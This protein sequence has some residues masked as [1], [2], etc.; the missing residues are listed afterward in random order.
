MGVRE[1][2]ALS[3]VREKAIGSRLLRLSEVLERTSISRTAI[4][5]LIARG[6]FPPPVK[7]GRMSRWIEFE[8]QA[9]IDRLA[10]ERKQAAISWLVESNGCEDRQL[11]LSGVAR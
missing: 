10:Q 4:Y 11:P 1:L 3:V 7:C 6:E 8:V 2:E 9:W 5:E